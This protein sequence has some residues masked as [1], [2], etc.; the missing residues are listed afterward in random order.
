MEHKLSL[1]ELTS[2][3]EGVEARI[4]DQRNRL[5]SLDMADPQ[6]PGQRAVLRTLCSLSRRLSNFRDAALTDR[7]TTHAANH[8]KPRPPRTMVQFVRTPLRTAKH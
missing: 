2:I 4:E 6:L 7:R 8:Y 3:L 5:A 1:D